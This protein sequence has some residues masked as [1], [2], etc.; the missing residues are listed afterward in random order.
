[1]RKRK[2][3]STA[4][5]SAPDLMSELRKGAAAQPVLKTIQHHPPPALFRARAGGLLCVA[6]IGGDESRGDSWSI[7]S[8]LARFASDNSFERI[9]LDLN[10]LPIEFE[11][12]ARATHPFPVPHSLLSRLLEVGRGSS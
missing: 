9:C 8:A 2:F 12:C 10:R 5:V 7:A 11:C 3:R 4:A 6:P 1:V